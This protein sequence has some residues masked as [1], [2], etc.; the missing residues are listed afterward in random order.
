MEYTWQARARIVQSRLA[1]AGAIELQLRNAHE[2]VWLSLFTLLI[3][4]PLQIKHLKQEIKAKERE[5]LE[6]NH[7]VTAA[8]DRVKTVRGDAQRTAT[9]L[10]DE[11]KKLQV[12]SDKSQDVA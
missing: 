3:D 1:A 10:E 6:Q 11:N 2:E 12:V 5:I 4:S 9:A 7:L 8:N